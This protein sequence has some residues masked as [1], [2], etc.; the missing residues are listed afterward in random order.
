MARSSTPKRLGLFVLG[1]LLLWIP[2]A[3]PI[4]LLLGTQSNLTSILIGVTLYSA[5]LGMVWIWGRWVW[6]LAEPFPT[7][8]LQKNWQTGLD[9]VIGFGFALLSLAGFFGVEWLLGLAQLQHQP[10][11]WLA[12]WLNGFLV[13]VGVGFLEELFFRGWLLAELRIGYGL[14]RAA[15][16]SSLIFALV[17]FLKPLNAILASWPQ[18][19]GLW[20]LGMLLVQA[21]QLRQGRLGLPIGLHGGW[22]C[23]ITVVNIAGFIV[24][25][26]T[27]P[28]WITGIGGNPLAGMMGLL[29]LGL[30][31][32]GFRWVSRIKLYVQQ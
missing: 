19:P 22:V 28:K 2:V 20:L 13:G 11:N 32:L 23:G 26:Q 6:G 12:V 7:Y 16:I 30:I 4:V 27:V 18:F 8:G 10:V 31:S 5:L 21:K 15:W 25:P 24:Y 29:F 9:W 17:H 1:L 3:L 14:R